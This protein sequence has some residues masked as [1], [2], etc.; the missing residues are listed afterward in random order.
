M[1]AAYG[2]HVWHG[3]GVDLGIAEHAYLHACAATRNCVLPS[4]LVGSWVREH[5]LVQSP[6]TF[7]DGHAVVPDKPG[8]GCE[9]DLDAI[10]HYE[11]A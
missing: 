11:V 1:A 7:T 6:M 5:M 8:L 3:S 9:L 4:D 2:S 10:R